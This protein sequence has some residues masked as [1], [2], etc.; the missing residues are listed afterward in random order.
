MKHRSRVERE[1]H[2]EKDKK[3]IKSEVCSKHSFLLVFF[4]GLVLNGFFV[5]ASLVVPHSS[6]CD[7]VSVFKMC[8][9]YRTTFKTHS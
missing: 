1:E 5:S 7:Y 9:T 2:E 6:Y 3:R 8:V 4:D